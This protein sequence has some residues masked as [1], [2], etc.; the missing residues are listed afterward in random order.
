MGL[1]EGILSDEIIERIQ[2]SNLANA[3]E[4]ICGVI[5]DF[6][7]IIIIENKED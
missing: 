5:N 6:F 1:V 3:C 2:S 7:Q 4:A